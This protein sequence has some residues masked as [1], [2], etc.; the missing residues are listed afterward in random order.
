MSDTFVFDLS[1]NLIGVPIVY[2]RIGDG[3]HRSIE[4]E[5]YSDGKPFDLTGWSI[6]F[7]GNTKDN[8][9]K[10]FDTTGINNIRATGGKFNYTFPT[11]A[12][13]VEGPYEKAYFSFVKDGTRE[14]TA[15]FE[16]VVFGNAD[17]DALQA[18]I[19]ITEYN[20]LIEEIYSINDEYI[21]NAD[22][23]FT[24]INDKFTYLETIMKNYQNNIAS[25][26]MDAT[27]RIDKA[28]IAG[29]QEIEDTATVAIETV[30]KALEEF[31]A[32][33]FYTK[34]ESD[35]T[36]LTKASVESG[37][38]IYRK[39]FITTDDWNDVTENGIYYCAAASGLNMPYTGKLYG[40]LTVYSES[41][42]IIQKYEFESSIYM[43]TYAGNPQIW[44]SWLKVATVQ[45]YLYEGDFY[46]GTNHNNASGSPTKARMGWGAE[47]N[48]VAERLGV[49][50]RPC[51]LD[52]NNGRWEATF[53][54]DCRVKLDVLVKIVGL[55]EKTGHY[56]YIAYWKDS[57]QTMQWVESN[58]IG[59]NDDITNRN[60]VPMTGVFTAKKGDKLSVAVEIAAGKHVQMQLINAHLQELA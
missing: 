50:M 25:Q 58:G 55:G 18:E 36:F 10:I 14:S 60:A 49:P 11:Q 45:E 21:K 19:I 24:A 53:N 2:G 46:M 52:F 54:R 38:L 6:T 8:Q 35:A 4:V 31:K 1:K 57:E 30:N 28:L 20:K 9:T 17:I 16:V 27:N 13:S 40:F 34:T 22:K 42:V 32:S 33:D 39:T 26:A 41:A 51:P 7:E 23:K 29:R 44:S 37:P 47:I 43:R 56:C 3:G 5:V 15:D 59:Q 12:F 48:T